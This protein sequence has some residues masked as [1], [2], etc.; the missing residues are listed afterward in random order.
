MLFRSE[1]IILEFS[2]S[3]HL[4]YSNDVFRLCLFWLLDLGVCNLHPSLESLLQTLVN[5]P[6][7]DKRALTR[8]AVGLL[9]EVCNMQMKSNYTKFRET[10]ETARNILDKILVGK[11]EGNEEED[12]LESGD[13]AVAE[14]EIKMVETPITVEET[15]ATPLHEWVDK[16]NEKVEPWLKISIPR[17]SVEENIRQLVKKASAVRSNL[18]SAAVVSRFNREEI[19]RFEKYWKLWLQE[20][21]QQGYEVFPDKF[22]KLEKEEGR[23]IYT[24]RP[25]TTEREITLIMPG[26]KKKGGAIVSE[27]C[28]LV[29]L[30][31]E[32][33]FPQDHPDHDLADRK[34]VV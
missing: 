31:P 24:H 19:K 22:G 16:W 18:V 21:E 3:F 14:S 25:T 33:N 13:F 8:S 5:S 12:F 20:I 15:Q 10:A 1:C 34:S 30:P 23:C 17:S 29:T 9:R 2:P 7:E 27:A 6:E 11:L 26:I 28:T 32:T 4:S